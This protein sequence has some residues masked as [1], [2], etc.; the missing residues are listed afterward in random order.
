M[1]DLTKIDPVL[2]ENRGSYATVRSAHEDCK[3]TL[4][5][6]CGELASTATKVLRRMQPDNDDIPDGIADLFLNARNT[7]TMM[8][9][10]AAEIESLAVQRAALK[11]LAWPK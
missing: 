7:L 6:L 4:Q 8:E 5:M 10:C 3:K 11:P 2:L 9:N 1:I